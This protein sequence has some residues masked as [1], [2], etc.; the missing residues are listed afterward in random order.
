MSTERWAR[1]AALLA[2]TAEGVP[3][4]VRLAG[5]TR[6]LLDASHV[7]LLIVSDGILTPIDGGDETGALLDEQQFGLGDGP[8]LQ[9]ANAS[10]PVLASDLLRA[11][12]PARWPLFGPVAAG[13]GVGSVIALPLGSGAARL[14]VLTAYRPSP[15]EPDGDQLTDAIV[16]ATL[17]TDL[18]L[19]AQ[20]GAPDEGLADVVAR[21]LATQSVIH[22]AAGMLS[23]QLGVNIIEALV[24]LRAHATAVGLPLA[25]VGRSIVSGE[26]VLER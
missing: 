24:R 5:A 8:T 14:G 10:I 19:A 20:A 15:A 26:L 4:G 3:L 12:T 7:G 25:T 21:G 9:A 13:F 1:V 11:G 16:L 17:A 22:Q 6:T 2:P 23:E 18:L